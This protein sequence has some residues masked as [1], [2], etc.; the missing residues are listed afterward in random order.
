[1]ITVETAEGSFKGH[2]IYMGKSELLIED[3]NKKVIHIPH[4]IIVNIMAE[5]NDSWVE[6]DNVVDTLMDFL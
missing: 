2:F 1:M 3:S 4:N 5:N 6:F